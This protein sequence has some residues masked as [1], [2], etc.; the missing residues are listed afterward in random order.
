M[1]WRE[2]PIDLTI[3][4]S[5]SVGINVW[6]GLYS[7]GIVGPVFFAGNINGDNYLQILKWHVI[8]FMEQQF[9]E[10]L[11][12]QDGAPAHYAN[13][14]RNYLNEKL[15]HAWIGRRGTTEWPARSPDL[16]PL[17]FLFWGVMKDRVYSKRFSNLDDL[18]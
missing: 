17:D 7:G 13:K 8:R 14:V 4:K 5:K 18:K 9:E 10:M 16:T 1:Y 6:C 2:G 15:E 3:G 12:Q 11:F